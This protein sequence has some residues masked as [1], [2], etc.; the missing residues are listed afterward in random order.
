MTDDQPTPELTP[1][2]QVEW[3]NIVSRCTGI[4]RSGVDVGNEVNSAVIRAVDARLRWLEQQAR[5][6]EAAPRLAP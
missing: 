5:E 4:V 2:Q 3:D 1:R 6:R